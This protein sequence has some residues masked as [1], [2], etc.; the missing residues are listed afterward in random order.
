MIT[1]H[2]LD[3]ADY[4]PTVHTSGWIKPELILVHDTSSR[5]TKGNVVN[6][7]KKNKPKAS[8]HV[9][10]ERDGTI[11]QMAPFNRRCHHAGRSSFR[12]RKYCNGFSIGIG[13]V[14]P[15]PLSGTT[16]KAKS[17]FGEWYSEGIVD[18]RSPHHGNSHLWLAYT[19]EQMMALDGV[20]RALHS[21]YGDVPVS[22]HYV[23]SPGRKVDPAPTLNFADL[24]VAPVEVEPETEPADKAL[25]KT[26]RK[27]KTTAGAKHTLGGVGVAA[28]GLEVSK[29]VG[30]DKISSAK[31]YFDT[32]AGFVS[33]YGVT[34]LIAACVGG[35]LITELLLKW[36]R[37][38][39]DSG[40]YEP[41]E[42]MNEGAGQWL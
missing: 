33:S 25:A 13:I 11:V 12:G 6:Y 27:Y 20:V 19:P 24:G 35:W 34:M 3:G 39:Y 18:Q 14:S 31:I 41:S 2:K 36:Q 42:E 29:A 38:D 7:L 28:I 23:V 8:Y 1:N 22:G 10:I 17:W 16:E 9:V 26:S 32:V 40:R 15:G 21:E 37:E 4:V 5:L 30:V